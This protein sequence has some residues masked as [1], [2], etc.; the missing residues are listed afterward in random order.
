MVPVL[1]LFLMRAFEE[2]LEKEY[3]R[4]STR[5]FNYIKHLTTILSMGMQYLRATSQ[6][7]TCQQV[8]LLGSHAFS[9]CRQWSIPICNARGDDSRSNSDIWPLCLILT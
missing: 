3:D 2:L 6:H 7:N 5:R 8:G 4:N 9:I 1:F